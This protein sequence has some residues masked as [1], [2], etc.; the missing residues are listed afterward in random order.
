M[1]Y[2][3]IFNEAAGISIALL[4]F[5]EYQK[6]S[7]N[8]NHSSLFCKKYVWIKFENKSYLWQSQVS[9]F[10]SLKATSC[11][12]FLFLFLFFFLMS[13]E[14][15]FFLDLFVAMETYLQ[16]TTTGPLGRYWSLLHISTS[17]IIS[18]N[19][20]GLSGGLLS[21]HEVYQ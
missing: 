9:S 10:F 15:N 13:S 12:L 11:F 14:T 1:K 6:E 20:M 19:V 21:G 4:V 3:L 17:L 8:W 5:N 2:C 7:L 16:C 18:S